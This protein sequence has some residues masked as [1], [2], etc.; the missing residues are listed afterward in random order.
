MP[1]TPL[2]AINDILRYIVSHLATDLDVPTP[3][4]PRFELDDSGA[5]EAR[6]ALV[7]LA[8]AHSTFT[9][10]ALA[11]LWRFLPS[12]EPL[13]HL[14]CV[15]GIA[16]RPP[17]DRNEWITLPMVLLGTPATHQ[18]GWARFQEYA[19][20][21]R[22]I[23]ID[24]SLPTFGFPTKLVQDTFWSQVSS[25]FGDAPILPQLEAATLFSI[26]PFAVCDFDM[27]ALCLLNPSIRELNIT[28]PGNSLSAC[29]PS[30]HNL[31][32]LSVVVPV[33]V[34]EIETLPQLYPRL[35]SLKVD[36][37]GIH[38]DDL[39]L[40]AT[41]PNLE[42][43]S[44]VLSP[45]APLNGPITFAELRSLDVFSYDFS[46]VGLLIAH[47][48]APKLQSLS[49]SESHEDS[50]DT[51]PQELSTHLRTLVQKHPSLTAFR[52]VARDLSSFG[53]PRT[54]DTT[55]LAALFAPLLS[56]LLSMRRFSASF[57]PP[58]IPCSESPSDFQKI[59]EA[60]GRPVHALRELEVGSVVLTS[61]EGAEAARQGRVLRGLMQHIFP[62]AKISFPIRASLGRRMVAGGGE[63]DD[64][65]EE[66]DE[67]DEVVEE[68]EEAEE[69]EDMESAD[70]P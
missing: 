17:R 60:W 62:G 35:R 3:E 9:K 46:D 30:G 6:Q 11:A 5:D 53:H 63:E 45:Y 66:E 67:E 57:A 10:P 54:A 1:A 29:L 58:Y 52:W 44:I 61:E 23:T 24:P 65:D 31:E 16:Q 18:S 43:L 19:S 51:Y 32:V 36:E 38:P 28:C 2:I 49:V 68:G 48:D 55:S 25:T 15:V 50:D 13:K 22:T 21:V 14:L 56:D 70:E 34:L 26:N 33:A 12:E 42:H 20:R 39:A 7:R 4:S 47:V 37:D 59:A 8:I 64:D 40:F 69:D 41:L 27:G